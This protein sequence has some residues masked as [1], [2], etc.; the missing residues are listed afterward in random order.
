M[1]KKPG[2]LVHK[3]TVGPIEFWVRHKILVQHIQ[4]LLIHFT[5]STCEKDSR[6][7]FVFPLYLF[8]MSSKMQSKIFYLSYDENPKKREWCKDNIAQF[9]AH[10]LGQHMAH[11]AIL[12]CLSCFVSVGNDIIYSKCVRQLMHWDYRVESIYSLPTILSILTFYTFYNVQYKCK[13]CKIIQK[14]IR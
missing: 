10:W 4:L 12:Y 14:S 9:S 11:I 5:F 7:N 6:L 2:C 3:R 1:N 8:I 13:F